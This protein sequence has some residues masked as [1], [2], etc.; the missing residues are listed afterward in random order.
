MGAVAALGDEDAE[1]KQLWAEAVQLDHEFEHDPFSGTEKERQLQYERVAAALE[2]AF[3][4]EAHTV[5]GLAIK[6]QQVM[7]AWVDNYTIEKRSEL[8]S[9]A[10]AAAERF[11]PGIVIYRP[12]MDNGSEEGVED[13][14]NGGVTFAGGAKAGIQV[15][16]AL[17]SAERWWTSDEALR[18]GNDT[19]DELNEN[20]DV[21]LNELAAASATTLDGV[22]AKLGIL[23]RLNGK[24]AADDI[25]Q[26]Q[27]HEDKLLISLLRDV[28]NMS[29]KAG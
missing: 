13:L 19:G 4:A 22:C 11:A 5:A 25:D 14:D 27:F 18:K 20:D 12:S 23:G 16:P 2:A 1:L 29:G 24:S 6:L 8:I 28:A 15:D 10:C 17:A 3:T 9:T 21:A 7:K 26:E